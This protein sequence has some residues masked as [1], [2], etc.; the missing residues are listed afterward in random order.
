LHTDLQE[1]SRSLVRGLV[2]AA[3][4]AE[5]PMVAV[6]IGGLA[7][8]FFSNDEVDDYEGAKATPEDAYA[9]FFRGMLA[10][11]IFIP[12]SRFEALFLSTAHTE[13]QIDRVA[14]AAASVF[15]TP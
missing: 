7:G 13:E 11:G 9:R 3:D 1:R 12:P 8:F 4:G 6:A 14:A 15:A 2:D 5:V 10:H